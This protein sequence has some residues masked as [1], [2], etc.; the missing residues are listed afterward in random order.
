MGTSADK[1][2][3]LTFNTPRL[4]EY[5]KAGYVLCS[6]SLYSQSIKVFQVPAFW[7]FQNQLPLDT[8]LR[9]V[10]AG[11]RALAALPLKNVLIVRVYT[12]F[13]RSALNGNRERCS[14]KFKN[15]ISFLKARRL[16]KA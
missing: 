8:N 12:S 7:P 13:S 5:I 16:V 1:T 9:L 11:Q 14:Q 3:I 10:V 4:P 6:V 2:L 15:N